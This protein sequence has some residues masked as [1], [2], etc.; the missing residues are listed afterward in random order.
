M[1]KARRKSLDEIYDQLAELACRLEE[2]RDEEQFYYD[3]M[4]EGIQASL[5]GETAE[6]AVSSMEEALE[7]IE[8]ARES[9]EASKGGN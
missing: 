6:E 9:I 3:N 4:P 7:A 2:L 8:N 1:N 5:K